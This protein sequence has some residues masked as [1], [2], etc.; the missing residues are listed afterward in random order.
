VLRSIPATVQRSPRNSGRAI[1]AP[2]R[3]ASSKARSKIRLVLLLSVQ[4]LQ[5][6]LFVCCGI[7]SAAGLL[8]NTAEIE[9][10]ASPPVGNRLG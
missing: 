2:M 1:T 9:H 5:H 3:S 7:L 8:F 10:G 4:N 6:A